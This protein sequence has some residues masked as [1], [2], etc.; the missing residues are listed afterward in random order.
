MCRHL[1]IYVL[2]NL[3]KGSNFRKV[4]NSLKTFSNREQREDHQDL[5]GQK[6]HLGRKLVK[7]FQVL[8]NKETNEKKKKTN[9]KKKNLILKANMVPQVKMD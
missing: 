2:D 4:I 5:V 9:E 6:D 1:C 3:S 7:V 8:V